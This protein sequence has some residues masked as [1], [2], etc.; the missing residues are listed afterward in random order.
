MR[1]TSGYGAQ[2]QEYQNDNATSDY[3]Q[4]DQVYSN[5]Y[6][7][8]KQSQNSSSRTSTFTQAPNSRNNTVSASHREQ[9]SGISRSGAG[10]P[11]RLPSA[12]KTPRSR[13]YSSASSTDTRAAAEEV[14]PLSRNSDVRPPILTDRTREDIGTKFVSYAN[15]SASSQSRSQSGL[16]R[17]SASIC[18]SSSRSSS[19]NEKAKPDYPPP[20]LPGSHSDSDGT[21]EFEASQSS[22]QNH[23]ETPNMISW[24]KDRRRFANLDP[25]SDDVTSRLP[26]ANSA[27]HKYEQLP[28]QVFPGRKT[29]SKPPPA[30]G[31]ISS[32]Q[33]PGRSR[34]PSAPT[35]PNY[36]PL[37]ERQPSDIESRLPSRSTHKSWK[38]PSVDGARSK[39][40]QIGDYRRPRN[41]HAGLSDSRVESIAAVEA[42]DPS[43]SQGQ[44]STVESKL[45]P[46]SPDEKDGTDA[47]HISSMKDMP[48]PVPPFPQTDLVPKNRGNRDSWNPEETRARTISSPLETMLM[49]S[50]PGSTPNSKRMSIPTRSEHGTSTYVPAVPTAPTTLSARRYSEP[51]PGKGNGSSRTPVRDQ[52]PKEQEAPPT[53]LQRLVRRASFSAGKSPK[54]SDTPKSLGGTGTPKNQAEVEHYDVESPFGLDVVTPRATIDSREK[55]SGAGLGRS[56]GGLGAPQQDVPLRQRHRQS[57]LGRPAA[58]PIS[59]SGK[60]PRSRAVDSIAG[61]QDGVDK[62]GSPFMGDGSPR[63]G[64]DE[65]FRS[66]RLRSRSGLRNDISSESREEEESQELFDYYTSD[67]MSGNAED[68]LAEEIPIAT[69]LSSP[70]DARRGSATKLSVPS[71][72]TV[73]SKRQSQYHYAGSARAEPDGSANVED[74]SRAKPVNDSPRTLRDRTP[75]RVTFSPKAPDTIWQSIRSSSQSSG[76]S[77][78]S[79]SPEDQ[80][81][82]SKPTSQPA[83][84]RERGESTRQD[85]R[86]HVSASPLK[87]KARHAKQ[88]SGRTTNN[89]AYTQS[90]TAE[91]C[92]TPFR[93]DR[94]SQKATNSDGRTE[95]YGSQL[96]VPKARKTNSALFRAL[97][98]PYESS[99]FHSN[100]STD[101][102]S[103]SLLSDSY[104]DEQTDGS[105]GQLY[106][107]PSN[108]SSLNG[109]KVGDIRWSGTHELSSATDVLLYNINRPNSKMDAL[110]VGEPSED[111][112]SNVTDDD[113]VE[114]AHSDDVEDGQDTHGQSSSVEQSN[115][116][117]LEDRTRR[118]SIQD[119][120]KAIH[121]S[122][123]ASL[124]GDQFGQ[125]HNTLDPM[126]LD[127]QK[128]IWALH[129][130]EEDY[131]DSLQLAL[132]LFVR[133]LRTQNQRRWISGLAPDVM[134]LF[135]WLDDIANLHEQLLGALDTLRQKNQSALIGF[136]DTIRP[137]VPL[138]ELYQPYVVRVEEISKHIVAMALDSN[139]DFGEFVRIQSALPEC[140]QTILEDMLAK[141]TKRLQDYVDMFQRILTLTPRTHPDYL[142]TFSL[143]HAMHATTCVIQ[144]VKSREEEYHVIK[145]LLSRA[146]GLPPGLVV[147][148]RERRLLA[149][150][151]L[152][153]I[154]LPRN[155]DSHQL[156]EGRSAGPS[157]IAGRARSEFQ[158]TT[159]SSATDSTGSF[160][161][162]TSSSTARL[163]DSSTEYSMRSDSSATSYMNMSRD[164]RRSDRV[165]FLPHAGAAPPPRTPRPR[166]RAASEV[167]RPPNIEKMVVYVLVFTDFIFLAKPVA[168]ASHPSQSPRTVKF[169]EEWSMLD[170]IG[171]FR[172]LGV[173]DVSK[174]YGMLFFLSMLYWLTQFL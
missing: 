139:S 36:T 98:Q 79:D 42:R 151:V 159:V 135:D 97:E 157:N 102:S 158:F 160:G 164:G 155:N 126:E 56:S 161:Q 109:D 169:R 147:A 26:R 60:K 112:V 105:I 20:P 120:R 48:L 40:S 101:I 32:S 115:I 27:T 16:P 73:R 146:Q 9:P 173:T 156:A 12:L 130:S 72:P 70:G 99:P 90:S 38:E 94:S 58:P 150:G 47:I 31:T 121:E 29:P 111:Y 167:R 123:R 154:D 19:R 17:R 75:S 81:V 85:E 82:T 33:I 4:D 45:K 110:Q 141:P 83:G 15:T 95:N 21:R 6:A 44:K 114:P 140:E 68:Y 89:S 71:S 152:Q 91:P 96:P 24:A 13:S 84:R 3:S 144:E 22:F 125:L 128:A 127:R 74:H 168:Q 78:F 119:K 55:S 23:K 46:G 52:T 35:K 59:A 172:V 5:Q 108:L 100:T 162:S 10:I 170:A 118:M 34:I 69:V 76:C 43:H 30:Q 153:Q 163:K 145:N 11:S 171:V 117:S 87:L 65:R 14:P 143:L 131:V 51:S 41:A 132:R 134:R 39:S 62:L 166:S 37:E 148:T 88:D 1:R 77:Q 2:N 106:T 133:P 149:Q 8:S 80:E 86:S 49:G 107:V 113:F 92:S 67:D 63:F 50:N 104:Q 138:M 25:S 174:Q 136:S 165:S 103:N 28:A 116:S 61:T 122:W 7:Y 137:F 129:E 124:E 93:R 54:P 53:I 66:P 57:S 18:R 142:A 64:I